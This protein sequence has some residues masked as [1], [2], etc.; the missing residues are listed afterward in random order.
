MSHTNAYGASWRLYSMF[1]R[2]TRYGQ[3][4]LCFRPHRHTSTH[5][6]G[7]VSE[8][9]RHDCFPIGKVCDAVCQLRCAGRRRTRA[10]GRGKVSGQG[11]GAGSGEKDSRS[12]FGTPQPDN[13]IWYHPSYLISY[14]SLYDLTPG[15]FHKDVTMVSFKDYKVVS[16]RCTTPIGRP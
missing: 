12:R 16:E 3:P 13:I 7:A 10:K 11:L 8:L 9:Q 14:F 5:S 15:S 1:H 4:A 2:I 6:T